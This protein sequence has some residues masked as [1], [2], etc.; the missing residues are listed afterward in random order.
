M[1]RY[2]YNYL[3]NNHQFLDSNDI[4]I[5]FQ[6]EQRPLAQY[7]PAR[8]AKKNRNSLQNDP[9]SCENIQKK[10]SFWCALRSK[11]SDNKDYWAKCK[12]LEVISS[13]ENV[14]TK[15]KYRVQFLDN[16]PNSI[17]IVSGFEI[18]N[19]LLIENFSVGTRVVADFN[20][21]KNTDNSYILDLN[22]YLPGVI[23]EK[24][25]IINKRRYLVFSDLGHYRYIDADF[26][27]KIVEQSGAVKMAEIHPKIRYFK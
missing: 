4:I 16:L 19:T 15:N 6:R 21:S 25:T 27:L 22:K 3:L 2:F 17:A 18:S 23:L 7:P 1:F 14:T 13:Y 12:L 9:S 11:T 24:Q 8:N 5:C 20:Q 26:V 10:G